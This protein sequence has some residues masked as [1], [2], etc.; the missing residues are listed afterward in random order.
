[1]D[2]PLLTGANMDTSV[3]RLHLML[4]KRKRPD[5]FLGDMCKLPVTDYE[6]TARTG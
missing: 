1:M 3:L 4:Q 5:C 2:R 6:F